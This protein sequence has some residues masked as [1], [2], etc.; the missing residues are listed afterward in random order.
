MHLEMEDFLE[1]RFPPMDCNKKSE[2]HLPFGKQDSD[3]S[4][5]ADN[6]T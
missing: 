1:K 3:C 6:R 4:F 5:G 2:S